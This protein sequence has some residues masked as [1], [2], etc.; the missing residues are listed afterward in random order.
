MQIDNNPLA[1]KPLKTKKMIY[2][3]KNRLSR[4]TN[5]ILMKI[6]IEL[7]LGQGDIQ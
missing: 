4:K 2:I 7:I 5:W 3:Y 6:L 1:V